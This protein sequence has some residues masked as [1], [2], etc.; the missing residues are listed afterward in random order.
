[1]NTLADIL[2]N[3][4]RLISDAEYMHDHNRS[5]SAANRSYDKSTPGAGWF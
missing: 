5:R 2:A 1:M 3:A 4:E